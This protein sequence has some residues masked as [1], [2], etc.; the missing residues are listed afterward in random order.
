MI[1]K[2][3]ICVCKTGNILLCI[4]YTFSILFYEQNFKSNFRENKHCNCKHDY[5]VVAQIPIIEILLQIYNIT[6]FIDIMTKEYPIYEN[7]NIE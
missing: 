1:L 7:I 3:G 5:N 4:M 2:Q 6:S